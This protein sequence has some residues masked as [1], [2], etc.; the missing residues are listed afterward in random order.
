MKKGL[1]QVYAYARARPGPNLDEHYRAKQPVRDREDLHCGATVTSLLRLSRRP[2]NSAG[3]RSS[4]GS[5]DYSWQD[6]GRG[7]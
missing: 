6:H 2:G 1:E 3:R 7:S 4:A 5:T